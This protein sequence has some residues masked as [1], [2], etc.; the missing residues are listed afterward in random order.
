[1]K[2]ASA[3]ADAVDTAGYTDALKN[4]PESVVVVAFQAMGCTACDSLFQ[5]VSDIAHKYQGKQ[6][7]F[8]SLS[9]NKQNLRL[10]KSLGVKSV[11]Y[12]HMYSPGTSLVTRDRVAAFS[13]GISSF[14][15]HLDHS[16]LEKGEQAVLA[17]PENTRPVLRRMLKVAYLPFSMLLSML[18]RLFGS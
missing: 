14:L 6:V 12:V 3:F 7:K 17:A 18:K 2:A 1:M 8:Y 11:P 15:Q 9:W 13:G 5:K 10:F 16:L 4:D